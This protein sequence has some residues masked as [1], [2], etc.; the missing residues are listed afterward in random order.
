MNIKRMNEMQK[1]E[2]SE[3]ATRG[4]WLIGRGTHEVNLHKHDSSRSKVTLKYF[5]RGEVETTE[6]FV[7]GGFGLNA[8][9]NVAKLIRMGEFA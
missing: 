3:T 7:I 1:Y 4:K 5:K 6:T 2:I 8:V 9:K